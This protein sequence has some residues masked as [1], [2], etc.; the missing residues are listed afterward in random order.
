[1][2][3][4]SNSELLANL[5]ARLSGEPG[6]ISYDL[7]SWQGLAQV[8]NPL[9]GLDPATRR[10]LALCRSPRRDTAF[11]GDVMATASF[12]SVAADRLA[13]FFR[14]LDATY[15]LKAAPAA[16]HGAMLAAA[17]DVVEEEITYVE[18]P[19]KGAGIAAG[20]TPGWLASLTE[21]FWRGEPPAEFPR[22]LELHILLRLPLAIVEVGDLR[23][24]DLNAFLSTEAAEEL[25]GLPDRR[26]HGCVLAYGGVGVVFVDAQDNEAERRVNLAHEVGHFLLDYLAVRERLGARDPDLLDVMDGLRDPTPQ[27]ELSALLADVP[28]G[29]QTH[30]L[31]RDRAG[32]HSSRHTGTVEDRAELVAWELLAPRDD[33]LSNTT[34][35]GSAS[36]TELLAD[37]YGLPAG[38]ASSYGGFLARLTGPNSDGWLDLGE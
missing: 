17:R 22:N 4:A 24:A 5:E 21:R 25:R 32:G 11:A 7:Q 31:E 34:N 28:L 36:L 2:S 27:E 18:T 15:S 16:Q 10:R 30:L 13:G 38:V 6:F 19:M 26:L 37:R 1:M 12:T 20:A 3:S 8:D 29:V 23:T 35:H 9:A 33:V 14:L